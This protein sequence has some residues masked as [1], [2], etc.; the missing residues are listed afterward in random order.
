MRVQT[1][2]WVHVCA[3][4]FSVYLSV[5]LRVCVRICVFFTKACIWTK[6]IRYPKQKLFS[7]YTSLFYRRYNMH[8]QLINI[9][10]MNQSL[11]ST[12]SS[13]IATVS[14]IPIVQFIKNKNNFNFWN[15]RVWWTVIHVQ[16]TL[17]KNVHFR[18]LL[19]HMTMRVCADKHI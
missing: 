13:F 12:N 3:W 6:T 9:T 16:C 4:T 19:L 1:S 8:P 5:H 18:Y 14:F 11:R 10:N 2:P 15:S 7:F 17:H